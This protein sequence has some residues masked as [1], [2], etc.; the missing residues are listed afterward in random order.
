MRGGAEKSSSLQYSNFE[1]RAAG[2]RKAHRIDLPPWCFR[3]MVSTTTPL[4]RR[5]ERAPLPTWVKPQ[6]AALLKQAPDGPDWLHEIKLDG[7]RMHAR[8]EAERDEA[9]QIS[10][11]TR[12]VALPKSDR[13]WLYPRDFSK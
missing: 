2:L 7:Y 11:L 5:I 9:Y 3:Q 10:R 12:R 6:L 1:Q 13:L 8:L 4:R